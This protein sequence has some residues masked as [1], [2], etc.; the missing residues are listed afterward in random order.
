MQIDH[1]PKT[2]EHIPNEKRPPKW[3]CKAAWAVVSALIMPTQANALTG[4]ELFQADRNLASGYV[5][6]VLDYRIN[7]HDDEVKH[8]N[9]MRECLVTSN[10][11]S[12]TYLDVVKRYIQAHPDTL[13]IPA[14]SAIIKATNEMCGIAE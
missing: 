4:A 1:D 13:P 9:K 8:Q 11:T 12:H 14:I 7:V 3:I 2:I 6:G 10:A 5:L